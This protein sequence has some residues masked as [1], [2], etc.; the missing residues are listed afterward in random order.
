MQHR[1][2]RLLARRQAGAR[3]PGSAKRWREE[4]DVDVSHSG[5]SMSAGKGEEQGCGCRRERRGK[6][7]CEGEKEL[8]MGSCG[9]EGGRSVAVVL[10]QSR[11][12][13]LYT[14]DAADDM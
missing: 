5:L 7:R 8:E 6:Q 14:S 13:L 2:T 4:T 9:R 1:A 3:A 11:S 10:V 12:C